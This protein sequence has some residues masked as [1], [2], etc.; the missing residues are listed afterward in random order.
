MAVLVTNKSALCILNANIFWSSSNSNV[1][2]K[3]T[4]MAALER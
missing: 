2:S 1:C 4:L 3:P